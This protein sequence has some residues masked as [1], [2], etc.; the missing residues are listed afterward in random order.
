[1]RMILV[2]AA[3]V[4]SAA[5]VVCAQP[6]T[7]GRE[8]GRR[9]VGESLTYEGKLNMMA[10]SFSV[11]DLTFTANES[12]DN[13]G[14]LI[15]AEATSKGTLTSLFHY[16]FLQQI[17]SNVDLAGFRVAKTDKHDV[18]K[19]RVRDSQAV[20]DYTQ[21]RVTYVETDPKDAMRAP[22]RIASDIT[23]PSYDLVSA[24][25]YVRLQD[26]SVGKT[27]NIEVSDSGLVYSVPV[28]VTG[29]EKQSTPFGKVMCWRIEPDLFGPGKLI[30]GSGK[31]IIWITADTRRIP[32]AAKVN[33]RVGTINIKLKKYKEPSTTEASAVK[34][35]K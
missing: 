32:V 18:Q 22:R 5:A 10:L 14:L 23:D 34:I 1:M 19:E 35:E 12:P 2:A 31:M 4:L 20:F 28:N 15:R 13:S 8:A 27:F 11:A 29:R 17:D 25:Y 21:K 30:D 9:F 7:A 33:A 6:S 24:I 26:L 16:S 3:L